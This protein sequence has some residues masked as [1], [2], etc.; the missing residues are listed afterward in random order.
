MSDDIVDKKNPFKDIGTEEICIEDDLFDNNNTETI[1]EVSKD[2]I[3][4]TKQKNDPFIDF[5]VNDSTPKN[6]NTIET[7]IIDEDDESPET[8]KISDDITIETII[9]NDDIEIHSTSNTEIDNGFPSC[10]RIIT[11]SA[12]QIRLAAE[13]I[14]KNTEN[15]NL[16]EF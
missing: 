5:R 15:K 13:R 14:K 2:K 12:N 8:I 3:N 10:T 11:T 6:E 16:A 7:I 4:E 9:I 1:T